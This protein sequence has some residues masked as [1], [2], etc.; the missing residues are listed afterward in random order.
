M[1]I[2]R[3]KKK[4]FYVLFIFVVIITLGIGYAEISDINLDVTGV[5]DVDVA[6]DVIITNVEYISS[7]NA[8][9][10]D[11]VINDTY[12]TML[13]SKLILGNSLDSTIGSSINGNGQPF[14]YFKG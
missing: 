12:L 3:S 7:N 2:I 14:R 5:A 9:D 8:N 6:S 13:N 11:T 1:N 10:S 4:Y